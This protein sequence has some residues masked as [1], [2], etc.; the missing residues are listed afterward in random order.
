LFAKNGGRKVR[1]YLA[2]F[3][4]GTKL[5]E[6]AFW[7]ARWAGIGGRKDWGAPFSGC[8]D[9]VPAAES[10]RSGFHEWH[11]GWAPALLVVGRSVVVDRLRP[12]FCFRLK[13]VQHRRPANILHPTTSRIAEQSTTSAVRNCGARPAFPAR[14]NSSASPAP[15]H[16]QRS[17]NLLIGSG[18]AGELTAENG[19][20]GDLKTVLLGVGSAG[21]ITIS[22]GT[23]TAQYHTQI[24]LSSPAMVRLPWA[25]GEYPTRH[26]VPNTRRS[27]Q[28]REVGTDEYRQNA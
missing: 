13:G 2:N 8:C 1:Q 7:I 10:V 16:R 5:A 6:S 26:S 28:C 12:E 27:R 3:T 22:D 21:T 20:T 17:H 9:L 4:R 24:G 11:P 14:G 15:A 25:P 23:V 19:A 18:G